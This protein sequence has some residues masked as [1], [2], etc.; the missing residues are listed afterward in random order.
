MLYA[1]ERIG[2]EEMSPFINGDR[3]VYISPN[4]SPPLPKESVIGGHPCRIW[5]K[6]QKNYCKRCAS[7]GHRTT[8]IGMCESYEP[9]CSV[10]AFRAN[11]NPLSNFYECTITI[12]KCQFKSAEHAYQWKKC[13]NSKRSDLAERVLNAPTP[14]K[15]KLITAE[16]EV[17]EYADTWD[18]IKT[19]VMEYVLRAKWNS[20]GLF[21]H[22]LMSTEGMTV[23]EAT[24]DSFWGVGV[25]PNLA[26]NTKPEKFLGLNHLGKILQNIRNH[27]QQI[28]SINETSFDNVILDMPSAPGSPITNIADTSAPESLTLHDDTKSLVE[29]VLTNNSDTVE[30]LNT[31]EQ[32]VD[33]TNPS[34][35]TEGAPTLDHIC[36]QDDTPVRNKLAPSRPPRS[37]NTSKKHKSEQIITMDRYVKR[38]S[39]VSSEK[40]KARSGSEST[41]PS[42][43]HVAKANKTDQRE[44]IS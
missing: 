4:C 10:M 40:R 37:K 17:N 1:K 14:A 3:L 36:G 22:T 38:D 43:A 31:T 7:H 21:R 41:S 42:S 23:A 20:C 11:N 9:D 18:S 25:A 12:G 5:H 39:S 24:Q 30:L 2:G 29:T 26:Q 35:S 13:K 15:A 27:V 16:L 34:P 28:S 19:T 6:S 44:G 32:P 33:D 8:D